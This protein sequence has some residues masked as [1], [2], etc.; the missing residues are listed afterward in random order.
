MYY[1]Y[2]QQ[3]SARYA[4]STPIATERYGH[5]LYIWLHG[6]IVKRSC[7]CPR[8]CCRDHWLRDVLDLGHVLFVFRQRVWTGWGRRQGMELRDLC[9]S[10]WTLKNWSMQLRTCRCKYNTYLS[11]AVHNTCCC[12]ALGE[13]WTCI[14]G[15]TLEFTLEESSSQEPEGNSIK[16]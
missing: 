3:V 13:V 16:I 9:Y 10:Y 7:C 2:V 4:W 6:W 12:A 11:I 14:G 5:D 15:W 1:I 8:H